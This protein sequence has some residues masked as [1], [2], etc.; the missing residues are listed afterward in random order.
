MR[1]RVE[2]RVSGTS[3]ARSGFAFDR[4][5]HRSTQERF[6]DE[7][8]AK[9]LA[10]AQ[11]HE[12]QQIHA[13][14]AAA[15]LQSSS[16]SAVIR[17]TTA[18]MLATAERGARGCLAQESASREPVTEA[19]AVGE[20]QARATS[21]KPAANAS[22]PMRSPTAVEREVEKRVQERPRR[23]GEHGDRRQRQRRQAQKPRKGTQSKDL[24]ATAAPTRIAYVLPTALRSHAGTPRAADRHLFGR[25]GDLILLSALL[26]VLHRR[27]AVPVT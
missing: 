19:G 1:G 27:F 3:K 8:H 11:R 12:A 16:P 25:V 21:R 18:S 17:P 7:R 9:P 2:Q 4:G 10:G 24:L 23:I 20:P 26:E 15:G 22:M 6:F 5:V 13:G 14:K